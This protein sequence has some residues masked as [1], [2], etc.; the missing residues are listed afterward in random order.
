LGEDWARWISDPVTGEIGGRHDSAIPS[1][2]TPDSEARKVP[3][4][5]TSLRD[6]LDAQ[7]NIK[8]LESYRNRK[9]RELYEAQDKIDAQRDELIGKIEA[10]LR[11]RKTVVPL[12]TVR[13]ELN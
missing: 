11:Q 2:N 4:L 8:N 6:K 10:Q 13:W 9:R 12:Y 1:S 7:K 5:A 3:A